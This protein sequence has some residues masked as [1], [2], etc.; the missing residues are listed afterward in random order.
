MT[1]ITPPGEERNKLFREMAEIVKEEVPIVPL[2]G[3]IRVGVYPKNWVRNFK[4]DLES[5]RDA[6][7]IDIEVKRQKEGFSL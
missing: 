4:R 2:F 3:V 7:H 1:K 5:G 6:V